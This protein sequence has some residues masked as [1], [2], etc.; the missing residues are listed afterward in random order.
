MYYVDIC[1]PREN[2]ENEFTIFRSHF[3]SDILGFISDFYSLGID[4][5]FYFV[6]SNFVKE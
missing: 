2:Y 1:F 6:V 3:L 4:V 5:P